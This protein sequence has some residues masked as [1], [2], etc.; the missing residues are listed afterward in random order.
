[1]KK[2]L[3]DYLPFCTVFKALR[4]YDVSKKLNQGGGSNNA[5]SFECVLDEVSV[6]VD[7]P[8]EIALRLPFL[9]NPQRTTLP[10]PELYSALD[11]LEACL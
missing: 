2:S 10:A 9:S 6:I 3:L 7:F 8:L 1:M 5:V 11:V 4:C